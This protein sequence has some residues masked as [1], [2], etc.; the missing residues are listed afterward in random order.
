MGSVSRQIR[1]PYQHDSAKFG[2]SLTNRGA[3][4]RRWKMTSSKFRAEVKEREAGEP[5]FVVLNMDQ[6]IGLDPKQIV[7]DLPSGTG[8][9][10]AR[11]LATALS[12]LTVSVR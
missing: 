5:C 7:F 3:P 9:P 1:D 6:S 2:Y 8:L 11:Q 10:E 4:N 12:G